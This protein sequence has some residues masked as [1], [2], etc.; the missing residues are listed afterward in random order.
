LD[1]LL[2]SIAA[3]VI[4]AIVLLA[5]RGFFSKVLIPWYLEKT[6]KGIDVTGRWLGTASLAE[7][8][9][10]RIELDLKQSANRVWGIWTQNSDKNGENR[11]SSVMAAEGELWEGFLSLS[12]KSTTRRRLAFGSALFRTGGTLLRG[13][14]IHRNISP[15]AQRDVF[16]LNLELEPD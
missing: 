11:R 15:Q 7:D 8:V 5:S 10:F 3:G 13:F 4:T 1:S 2:T 16:Y 12:L 6:Y 9:T 14:S